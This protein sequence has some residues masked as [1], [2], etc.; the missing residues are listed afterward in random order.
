MNHVADQRI[1]LAAPATA[2]EHAIMPDAGLDIV[3][4]LVGLEPAA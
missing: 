3:P 2:A 1:D 4:L